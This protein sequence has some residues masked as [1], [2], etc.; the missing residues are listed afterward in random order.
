[1]YSV[2]IVDDEPWVV[3]GIKMLINWE[4]LGFT[5][6]GEAYNGLEAL[7]MIVDK[8]PDIVITDIRMPGLSG[9][10]LLEKINVMQIK[11]KV[12]LISGY[13]EF[14]YAQKAVK[15][16]AFDYLLKQVEKESL[17]DVLTRVHSILTKE[18][19]LSLKRSIFLE[20]LF[21][22]LSSDNRKLISNFLEKKELKFNLLNYRFI[23]CRYSHDI[24]PYVE[25]KIMEYRGAKI[26]CLCTGKNKISALINYDQIQDLNSIET[27]ISSILPGAEYIGIS[28]TGFAFSPVSKLYQESEIALY[29]TWF[30]SDKRIMEYKNKFRENLF[31]KLLLNIELAIREQKLE[32]I[33]V[34]LDELFRECKAQEVLIDRI[35]ILYNHIVA[36]Y[37]KYFID[38]YDMRDMEYMNYYQ[39]ANY[40]N[41]IDQLFDMIKS[42]FEKRDG[43]EIRASNE[44]VKKILGYIDENFTGDISLSFLSKKFNMSLGYLSALIKRETGK[45][46]TDYIINKRLALAK[47]LLKDAT[48]SV[49]EI[50]YRVGYS[51]YFYFNKLFKKYVGITPSK[52]RKI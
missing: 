14:E 49:E 47:E 36:L 29:S 19:Q 18:R 45:T 7:E 26:L 39:I 13:S 23:N 17:I 20:D 31:Q 50:A 30:L 9:I 38:P 32:Q 3:Y 48:L 51:D 12:I 44:Q 1:M 27:I 25:E 11:T 21:E 2:L 6:V 52:Y 10:E 40:Y 35:S 24:V 33:N 4:D 42:F 28:S 43:K 8:K 15:L 46:Y 16:G 22:L 37:Y 5:V 34:L 41:S